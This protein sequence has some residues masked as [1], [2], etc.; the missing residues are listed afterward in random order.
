MY[1]AWRASDGS[2]LLLPRNACCR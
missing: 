1:A 2:M